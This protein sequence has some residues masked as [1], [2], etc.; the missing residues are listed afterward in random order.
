MLHSEP[1]HGAAPTRATGR[2]GG[3][4]HRLVA[5]VGALLVGVVGIGAGLAL[6]VTAAAPVCGPGG[7]V[8][9]LTGGHVV[10]AHADEAPPGVDVTEPV[11]TAELKER[12]GAGDAAYLAA[13]ELGV[14]G[15]Y[16]ANAS[17]PSVPCDGDGTSGH[18]VQAMYVVEQS[19]AN[20][21]ASLA[22]TFKL[23]AAGTDDVVNR[24]AALTGGVR[25]LRYVTEPDGA[26]GCTAKVLNVTVPDGSMSSFGAT[27]NAVQALGYTSPARKYLMWTDATTLCGIA[28]MYPYDTDGQSNPNNGSYAQYARIDS[29][30]WGLGNGSNQHSVEAHEVVH[31]LGSVFSTAPHGTSN[32]HCYDES[33]TMCYA[34]GG[35]KAMQQVCD[36]SQEYLLDCNSDDYFSTYPDPGSWLDTHWNAADNRFLIGGGDGSGG[37][38]AGAPTVLGATLAVNNP[39]IP[40]LPTQAEVSPSLPSGRTLTSVTWKAGRTDCTFTSPTELVT[41]V[42]CNATSATATTVTATVKD[43]TG[44]TKSVSSPLTFTTATPREVA[45]GLVLDSQDAADSATASVCTSTAFP[46]RLTAV[47]VATGVPVKGLTLTATK[48][49]DGSTTVTSVGAK[50]TDAS[51][52]SLLSTTTA[53]GATVTARSNAVGVWRAATPVTMRAVPARCAPALTVDATP[54]TSYY[55]AQVPVTGTVTREVGGETLPVSG[56]TVALKV[57]KA[58]GTSASLGS[59]KTLADGTYRLLTKPT[60]SGRLVASVAG[61]TGLTAATADGPALTVLVPETDLAATAGALDVGYGEPAS[62]TGRLER[63]AGGTVTPLA[64]ATVSLTVTAPGRT[65][66]TVGSGRTLADG[67]FTVSGALR[68]SGTLRAVYAGAAGQPAASVE[69]GQ[70]TAGTWTTALTA[71]SSASSVVLGGSVTL[72]GSLTKTYGGVTKAAGAQRVKVYFTPAGGVPV[73]VTSPTTTTTGAWTARVYP[74]VSGTWKAV[75]SPV[76]GYAGSESAP[77]AVSVG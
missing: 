19:R 44:A 5:V 9:Q 38:S 31:T 69:L 25:H 32:G 54:T 41:G 30:C 57:L 45:V 62:A 52:T 14:P 64:S 76:T 10:C 56:V 61:T 68:V 37:G 46:V 49:A 26:G 11:S 17:S 18:R 43:S 42:V 16:A 48:Q 47:D 55:G 71:S 35:G 73:L 70:A 2:P 63:D 23:W 12:P 27:V 7:E 4:A 3:H 22:S 40:G 8:V 66:V 59:V 51:G 50:A 74:K 28:S 72:N 1:A 77:V 6:S 33:D 34:D 75:L 13:E 15:Y 21:Y 36:P 53:V 58:N 24:S 29:G 67:T 20:R 60:V 65:P 39:A